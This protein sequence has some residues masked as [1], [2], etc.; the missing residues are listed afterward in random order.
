[1]ERAR[2]SM[3]VYVEE[4]RWAERKEEERVGWAVW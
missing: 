3:D 1:L 4:G 2:D